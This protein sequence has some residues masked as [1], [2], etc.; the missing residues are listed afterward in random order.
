[1]L[2]VFVT[3]AAMVAFTVA[4][5]VVV[6]VPSQWPVL[7]WTG[8]VLAGVLFERAR[9]G[10]ARERPVGGDWRPTPERFI[11]DASG[12]VMVVW[13]SPSSGERRY[14]ED[15]APINALANKLQ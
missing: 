10:A 8:V 4:L 13:I 7:I 3:V 9:Y 14:V 12:K 1:M 2:R 11:D 6:M 5:I 15:G